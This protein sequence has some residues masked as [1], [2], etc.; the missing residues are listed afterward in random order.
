[1]EPIDPF[2]EDEVV[3]EPPEVLAERKM[4]IGYHVRGSMVLDLTMAGWSLSQSNSY[5]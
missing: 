3:E 4:Q 5:T 2:D 1:L